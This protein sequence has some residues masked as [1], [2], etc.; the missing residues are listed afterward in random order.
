MHKLIKISLW[1]LFIS[2][3][4]VLLSFTNK[5]HQSTLCKTPEVK[6]KNDGGFNF[7]SEKIILNLLKNKGYN[8]TKQ[9]IEEINTGKIEEFLYSINEVERVEIFKSL[10]GSIFIDIKERT[11]VVRIINHK[12]L[13]FYIDNKGKVMPLSSYKVANTH[14]ANGN[15]F[16][17]PNTNRQNVLNQ[18]DIQL[19]KSLLDDIFIISSHIAKDT[20]LNSQIVQIYVDEQQDIILIPRVGEQH[21]IVG[22]A[23]N[24]EDKFFRLKYFYKNAIKPNELNKYN[25]LNLKYNK[26]IICSKKTD[27]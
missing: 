1:I 14:I 4:G 13:S 25:H 16:E 19:R 6:I 27:V 22:D 21:I 24:I 17:N 3:I 26:Q 9:T 12:G 11:P 10:D 18:N 2:G 8:F 7:L 15:I 20:F 23:S 5:K